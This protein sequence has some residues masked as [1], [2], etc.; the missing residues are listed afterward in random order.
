LPKSIPIINVGT[1]I[2]EIRRFRSRPLE[3]NSRF[4][5]SIFKKSEIKYC[6]KYS[7]PYPH[8][9]GI[10]AAKEAVVKCAPIP[11]R[12]IDVTIARDQEGRPIATASYDKKIINVNISISH[13]RALSIAV[14]ILVM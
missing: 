10:F 11:L 7:D 12:M 9:A 6:L 1:D 3:A 2:E 13:S 14:A 5:N 8:I 4:Y